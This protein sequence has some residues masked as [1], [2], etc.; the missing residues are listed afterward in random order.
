M[1]EQGEQIGV[2]RSIFQELN[3]TFTELVSI[4]PLQITFEIKFLKKVVSIYHRSKF[5]NLKL[6]TTKSM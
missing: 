4:T 1:T 3:K 2:P 5:V 6:T